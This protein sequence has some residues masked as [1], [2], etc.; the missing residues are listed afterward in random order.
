M[1]ILAFDYKYFTSTWWNV[2]DFLIVIGTDAGII[3]KIFG[4]GVTTTITLIRVF[5]IL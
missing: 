4:Y 5:R 1:K 3:M 2:F